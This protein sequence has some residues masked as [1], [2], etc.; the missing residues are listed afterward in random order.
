[1]VK[2]IE[3]L[4]DQV[5]AA[6]LEQKNAELSALEAQI[7]PHFLYNTLDTI[8]WK[9]IERGEFEIS[10]MVGALADILR[11]MVKNAGG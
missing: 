10:G 11:Y 8:N 7:D 4:I 3:M 6:I 2:H 5:K 9:A 1:M